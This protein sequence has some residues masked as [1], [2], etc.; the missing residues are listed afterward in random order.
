MK[1]RFLKLSMVA[2]TA[3]SLFLASCS[4]EETKTE[5]VTPETFKTTKK[6]LF[7][8][9]TGSE[10]NPCG[11]VGIPN[12]NSIVN[13]L[14]M[15]D[16]VVGISVHTNAPAKDSMA[17]VSDPTSAGGELIQ[18]IISGGSYS[19]PTF[20]LPPN[21]PSSGSASTARTTYTGY[22]NTFSSAAPVAAVNVS[23]KL[24]GG[25]YNIVTRTKFLKDD[26]GDFKVSALVIEDGVS[27]SQVANGVRVKPYIHDQVL[28]GKFCTSA[29]GDDLIKGAVTS[30]QIVEKTLLGFVP[31][32]IPVNSVRY[33]NKTNLSVV[34]VVWRHTMVGTTKQLE[35]INCEKIKL[36]L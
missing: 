3:G 24:V 9:Y 27:Y 13:D 32:D 34:V 21:A 6:A 4:K 5:T 26:N 31:I 25:I 19:A 10:C 18:L 36:P 15:K 14:N 1:N 35:V 8:Y 23:S 16:K 28:R 20:L 11:S 7:L 33:W 22:V 17:D 2:L 12:Y 30:G 29:F